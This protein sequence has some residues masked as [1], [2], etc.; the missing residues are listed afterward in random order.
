MLE[1]ENLIELN[2]TL[3]ETMEMSVIDDK[4]DKW[5]GQSDF[6]DWIRSE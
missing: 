3:E 4:A 6:G 1:R 5:D 2:G